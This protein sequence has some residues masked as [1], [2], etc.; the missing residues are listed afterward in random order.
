MDHQNILRFLFVRG[1]KT[2]FLVGGLGV[3]GQQNGLR[4][5][6][7]LLACTRF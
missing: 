5:V 4:G 1:L 7:I 3:R 2:I 6:R